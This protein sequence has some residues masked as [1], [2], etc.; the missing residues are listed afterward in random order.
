VLCNQPR[1]A[2]HCITSVSHSSWLRITKAFTRFTCRCPTAPIRFKRERGEITLV[3]GV[4]YYDIRPNPAF[5]TYTTRP[6]V[7]LML[8]KSM[9][10]YHSVLTTMCIPYGTNGNKRVLWCVAARTLVGDTRG[11]ANWISQLRHDIHVHCSRIGDIL[12]RGL[13]HEALGSGPAEPL[14]IRCGRGPRR[15]PRRK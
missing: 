11:A 1:I 10:R 9:F 4:S 14:M 2:V 13:L 15:S 12:K 8:S 5:K 7:C 3:H 6:V